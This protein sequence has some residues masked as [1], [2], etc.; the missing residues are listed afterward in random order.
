MLVCSCNYITD[1]DI[2]DT[3]IQLL[4]EDC[5]QLIVPSKVYHAMAKRGRCCGCFPNVVELI[6]RTTEEYHA[7][8][9]STEDELVVYLSRLKQFHEENR[10]ADIERR[11]K[12][13]RAA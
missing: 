6:I 8:R 1:K 3:I 7:L 12:G 9:H 10:R 5:W 4:D 13:H 11:L 2:R